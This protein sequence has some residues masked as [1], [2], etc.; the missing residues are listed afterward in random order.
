M[1]G[2]FGSKEKRSTGI[3]IGEDALNV[4]ELS[5]REHPG[6]RLE[7]LA[8][9]EL[10]DSPMSVR[11]ANGD[12]RSQLRDAMRVAV[13]EQGMSCPNPF[14]ALDPSLVSVKRR[15]LIPGTADDNRDQLRWEAE[16]V[17]SGEPG[18]FAI[19]FLITGS[20]G[21][22]VMARKSAV[23][24]LKTLCKGAGISRPRFDVLPFAL[25]NA[26]ESS[27]ATLSDST[28]LVIDIGAAEARIVLLRQGELQA[29]ELCHWDGRYSMYGDPSANGE[30][31]GTSGD[32][33]G[34][35][36]TGDA[37]THLLIAALRR[38]IGEESA[39]EAPDRAWIT[40]PEAASAVWGMTVE[41]TIAKRGTPLN[42]F[43]GMKSAIELPDLEEAPAFA[44]AA[45]L[46]FRGLS[47]E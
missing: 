9:I 10:A 45:G 1:V 44:I 5:R 34:P 42:P 6:V 27:G 12:L 16:Q 4:V 7:G 22:V 26:L 41:A 23:E 46:A 25:C 38:F 36:S 28:D 29:V 33:H 18:Q 14:V 37:R 47:E 31:A 17:L 43:S 3:H 32:E 15:D 13:R 8:R 39:D 35:G 30:D 20:Y 11:L 2:L 21:F 24:S 19:D 40:G